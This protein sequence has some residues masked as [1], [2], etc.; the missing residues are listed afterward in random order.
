LLLQCI[1]FFGAI[2]LIM[3]F[4][5]MSDPLFIRVSFVLIIVFLIGTILI[6]KYAK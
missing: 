1:A 4:S 3:L 5:P 6:E 2:I